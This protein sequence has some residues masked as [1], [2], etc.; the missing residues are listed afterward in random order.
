MLDTKIGMLSR[1]V[2][3]SYVRNIIPRPR[4]RLKNGY[5][6]LVQESQNHDAFRR[7]ILV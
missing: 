5:P 1:A 3:L 6:V 2:S 7:N 4:K